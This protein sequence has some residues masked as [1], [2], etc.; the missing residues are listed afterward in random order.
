MHQ[1]HEV[2]VHLQADFFLGGKLQRPANAHAG[3]VH[4][5]IDMAFFFND[6]RN[7]LHHGLAVADVHLYIMYIGQRFHLAAHGAIN[8]V[9]FLRKQP[10][11]FQAEA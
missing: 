9:A 2:G 6:F 10:C 1:A 4:Q 3:I 5:N 11:R 8:G 7:S